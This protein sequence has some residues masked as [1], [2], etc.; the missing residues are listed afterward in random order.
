MKKQ[1]EGL[2]LR[3][4]GNPPPPLSEILGKLKFQLGT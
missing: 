3:E 4:G 1:E 2:R